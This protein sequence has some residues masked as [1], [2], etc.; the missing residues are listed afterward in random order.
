MYLKSV[1]IQ[2]FKT[3]AKKTELL[4]EPGI[5]AVVGPNGSGK[6]NLVDAIR[7]VLGERSARELRGSR[8]EE[9]VYSGGARR[10]ASGMAEVRLV[11]DNSDARLPVPYTEI[12]VLRRGYRSGESDYFMN[13]AR[14]RLRDIEELFSS[15]GLTQEGYA[16]VA[17]DDVDR[18]IQ[19]S[20]GER[21]ALI[22]EAAGV[23]GLHAKRQEAYG[24]LKEA[25][26]SIL[27]LHDLSGELG[28][29]VEELRL[30]AEAARTHAEATSRLEALRGSL[31]RGEWL[32]ARQAVKRSAAK[33]AAANAAV[34]AS[35]TEAERFGREYDAAREE[36]ARAQEA[37]VDRERAIGTLR[38]AATHAASR[39][40]LLAE[41][42]GGAEAA[43]AAAERTL[44]DAEARLETIQ[45][46]TAANRHE[47]EQA[48]A[49]EPA[50]GAAPA[51][52]VDIEA[53]QEVHRAAA[54]AVDARRDE[55][56]AA[57]SAV[58]RLEERVRLIESLAAQG[59]L[60][61]PSAARLV[62][63]LE[64]DGVRAAAAAAGISTAEIERWREEGRAEQASL[65]RALEQAR[66][67]LEL[68]RK[69]AIA[70]TDGLE[71]GLVAL[72]AAA[73]ELERVREASVQLQAR[74][75]ALFARADSA[76]GRLERAEQALLRQQ[77][78]VA[79][80]RET[81]T[82]AR[83]ATDAQAR[84]RAAAAA[85]A[86]EAERSLAAAPAAA[87]VAGLDE[88]TARIVEMEKGNLERRVTVAHH[89]EALA[90]AQA[91]ADADRVLLAGVTERM[92]GGTEEEIEGADVDWEKTQREIVRLE[93]HL[94]QMGPVN[95]LAID[96]YERDS[97]R[98]GA[99]AG[100][101]DDLARARDG[102]GRL[103]EELSGEI[104]RRFEAVFG[105]VAFN[106]QETFA[107]L[108]VGGKATLKLD[109]PGA[110][111]PGVEILAQ[112][113]GKRMRNIR[114]LSGGER[115]LTALAFI[116][117][118]EK[119]NPSPFYIFDEVDAPLDDANVRRFS[120]MLSSMAAENQFILITHNHHTM[121]QA[122]ALYGVTLED[123][124]V[125]RVVSVR[126]Q[127]KQL[128]D[129]SAATG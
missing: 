93:R 88:L 97:H 12:E 27:R 125:S 44:A 86:A 114:L 9:V 13:G 14:C 19:T 101:L 47:V 41:R 123:S 94:A 106:F 110:D 15:T 99:I 77:A 85:E 111:E 69:E 124:G 116:L 72:A 55:Q 18:I 121:T 102:L 32:A 78:E 29:R 21:R 24:K 83:G 118:L 50:G 34:E 4:F 122:Q 126:L 87:E 1:H 109:D 16:V 42:I 108:F 17:Q 98:L 62:A 3:F 80:L 58:Q 107:A 45:A 79:R 52:A 82:G 128:V 51:P 26:I 103:A 76:R 39:V 6:S 61:A 23:R 8:M 67:D 68:A 56:Q 127:G 81:V 37:R 92:G 38:L 71:A 74:Q 75:L 57:S 64:H 11:I 53:A 95:E 59:E 73:A 129:A 35:R 60:A 119:V 5:T 112:P 89:E 91:Q 49:A 10:P 40:E 48:A 66:G 104:D 33:V 65:A 120:A 2:G 22:E 115:A 30:Q 54:A 70:A 46:E 84:E 113:A 105:A 28:P 20:P 7:W 96:E 100:Q 63:L 43:A 31:L 117:A 36:M 25:D 90:A